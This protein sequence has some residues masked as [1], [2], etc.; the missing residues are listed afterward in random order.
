MMRNYAKLAPQFWTGSTGRELR[1]RGFE[2]V[3]V[4]V[5]L[6]SSPHSNMLGLY[7][8]PKMYM[9]HETGLGIE[10]AL[11][12]LADCIDVGFCSYD[13]ATEMVYV[14]EMAAWQIAAD[15]KATDKRCSGIQKDYDALPNC[16]F[17]RAWFERYEKPFHL[18]RCRDF[19]PPAPSKTGSPLPSPY[20]APSKPGTGAGT[21][22]YSVA[23]ATAPASPLRPPT[24]SQEPAAPMT[25][26]DRL[27]ALGVGVFGSD[28][29]ARRRIGKLAGTYGDELLAQVIAQ[30]V[31]E[32]PAEPMS[33]VV[34][35]CD[36]AK[37][38]TPPR[39]N[40]SADHGD[41]LGDPTPDWAI[42][43]GFPDRFVAENAGC[44]AG[45]AS[46]FRDGKRVE[47]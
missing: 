20:E 35:M 27:W 1:R 14:H 9:A 46:K 7:Y 37:T 32:Q 45:N 19:E 5:Y 38:R 4:A 6:V 16:H 18:K 11:K 15:L 40:G 39:V 24:E 33:W 47:S 34:A 10:G 26:K 30:A 12:G 31:L 29:A 25:A 13:D 41:L 44:K 42:R 22:A 8:Q 23:K 21:G 43:A 36:S 28:A 2:A 17:L 3:I